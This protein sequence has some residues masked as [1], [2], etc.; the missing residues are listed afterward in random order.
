ML[1]SETSFREF[2][3]DGYT[4]RYVASKDMEGVETPA[5]SGGITYHK[6]GTNFGR[7]C[8]GYG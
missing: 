1:Q 5:L 8:K 2:E 3:F 6:S 7:L 4:Y